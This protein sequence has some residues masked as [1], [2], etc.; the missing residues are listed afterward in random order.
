MSGNGWDILMVTVLASLSQ[1]MPS[2]SVS[3]S[4]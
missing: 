4:E 3:G 1:V 2:Y